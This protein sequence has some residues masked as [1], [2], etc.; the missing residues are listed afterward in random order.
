MR[1]VLPKTE[2]DG[3]AG[4]DSVSGGAVM[5]HGRVAWWVVVAVAIM[6]AV[7]GWAFRAEFGR[8]RAVADDAADRA[9]SPVAFPVAVAPP[10]ATPPPASPAPPAPEPAPA[11]APPP[12]DTTAPPQADTAM[13]ALLAD[14]ARLPDQAT[15]GPPPVALQRKAARPLASRPESAAPRTSPPDDRRRDAALAAVRRQMARCR[16]LPG[17]MADVPGAAA[18]TV[19]V[20]LNPDATVRR[21]MILDPEPGA[22]APGQSVMAENIVRALLD[23]RCGPFP[24]APEDY[25]VWRVLTLRLAAAGPS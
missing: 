12:A 3:V 20:A 24:L 23:P 16:A 15:A 14:V 17:A 22:A 8:V 10:I 4:P 5:S 21:V 11:P 7:M 1:R 18:V 25:P 6:L 13:A 19:E 2:P 9:G